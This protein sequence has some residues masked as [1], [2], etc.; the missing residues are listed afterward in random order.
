[1]VQFSKLPTTSSSTA[2]EDVICGVHSL[3]GNSG[4][5]NISMLV[6]DRGNAMLALQMKEE[7]KR[8]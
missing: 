7:E 6:V 3:A 8:L 5:Y 2:V 4:M 1:M